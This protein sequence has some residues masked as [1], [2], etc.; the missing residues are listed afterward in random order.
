MALMPKF[1]QCHNQV[2]KALEADGWHLEAA[3]SKL[4]LSYRYGYVDLRMSR[5]R[6]GRSEQI[7]L[8]EVKCFPDEKS[9]TRE[10]YESVGQYL[11]YRAMIMELKYDYSLYL[12][13]PQHIF[14][15][16]FDQAVMRTITETRIKLVVIDL[17]AE[18][19]VQW[20]E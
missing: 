5:G 18:R 7:L 2:V 16:I 15:R 10:L 17:E 6:N 9:T 12:A 8:V 19:V 3:P 1:D 14:N 11:I 4:Y 13:V 20:V